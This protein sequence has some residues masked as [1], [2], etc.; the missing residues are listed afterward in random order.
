M[1]EFEKIFSFENLYKAHRAGKRHTKEVVEFELNL[2]RNL[3]VLSEKLRTKEY[4]MSGYYDFYVYDPKKRQI[5]ALHYVD[6]LIKE[7]LGIKYYS[8]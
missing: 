5:H 8:G 6:K 4:R 1:T 3:S 2:G 7:E